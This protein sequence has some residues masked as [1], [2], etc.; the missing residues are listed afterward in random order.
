MGA[1]FGSLL[2]MC[3]RLEGLQRKDS[4]VSAIVILQL[5]RTGFRCEPSGDRAG[6]GED[7]REMDALD[8]PTAFVPKIVL[9]QG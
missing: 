1:H 6:V 5:L 8:W 7:V 4:S 2:K 3:P 9:P